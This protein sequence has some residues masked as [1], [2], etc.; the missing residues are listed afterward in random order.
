[1]QLTQSNVVPCGLIPHFVN[2]G[3]RGRLFAN[4]GPCE[5]AELVLLDSGKLQEEF[6]KREARWERKHPDRVAEDDRKEQEAYDAAVA[7]SEGRV[8]PAGTAPVGHEIVDDAPP[9]LGA[10]SPST[11]PAAVPPDAA[12]IAS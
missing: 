6:A 7:L 4:R 8:P 9:P 2:E 11:S 3:Y 12:T 1:M 10:M 5:L